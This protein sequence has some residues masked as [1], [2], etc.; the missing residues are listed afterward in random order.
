MNDIDRIVTSVPL[1]AVAARV[2]SKGTH[3]NPQLGKSSQVES[4][5]PLEIDHTSRLGAEKLV[6]RKFGHMTVVG[7]SPHRKARSVGE[8][9]RKEME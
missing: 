4:D 1:D 8:K 5:T 9:Q 6:G 3:W 7:L 2:V